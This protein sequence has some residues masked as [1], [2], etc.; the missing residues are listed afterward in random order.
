MNAIFKTPIYQMR[1]PLPP[2]GNQDRDL[3]FVYV[4]PESFHVIIG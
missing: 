3:S 1:R 4:A 2:R